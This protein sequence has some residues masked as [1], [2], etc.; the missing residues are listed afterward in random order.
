VRVFVQDIT[1]TIIWD[2]NILFSEYLQDDVIT[3]KG[4]PEDLFLDAFIAEGQLQIVVKGEKSTRFKMNLKNGN[5]KKHDIDLSEVQFTKNP[6]QL[7]FG[8]LEE[9]ENLIEISLNDGIYQLNP[10][11]I[12]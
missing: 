5:F 7:F 8:P 9:S 10:T 12:E 11:K 4:K 2:K 3:S 6:Y 1:G